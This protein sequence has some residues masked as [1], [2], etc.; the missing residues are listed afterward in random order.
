MLDTRLTAMVIDRGGMFG[1]L[2]DRPLSEVKR[3]YK[4][5]ERILAPRFLSV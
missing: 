5:D 1:A 4:N 3:Q 2:E